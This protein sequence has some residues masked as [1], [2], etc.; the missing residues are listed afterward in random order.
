MKIAPIACLLIAALALTG[1]AQAQAMRDPTRPP[2]RFLDPAQASEAAAPQAA[3]LQTIKRTGKRRAALLNGEWLRPGER[4]GEATVE[5]ID[6]QS[7]V[8][9]HPDGRRETFW[10]YP[11]VE[12]Q[13]VKAARRAAGK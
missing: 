1:A 10:L 8:L 3:G 2:A 6:D 12:M 7:L 9:L 5:K 4:A 11:E 13:A